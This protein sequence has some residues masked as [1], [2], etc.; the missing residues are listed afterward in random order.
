MP[1]IVISEASAR[2]HALFGELQAPL[3]SFLEKRAEAIAE[4][5]IVNKI[6]REVKSTHRKEGYSGMTTMGDFMP[7]PENGAY[8]QTDF[9]VAYDKDIV[10]ITWKNRFSVSKEMMDDTDFKE[11]FKRAAGMMTDFE[12]TREKFFFRILAEALQ[13]KKSFTANNIEVDVTSY[14]KLPMFSKSH[15]GKISGKTIGNA[16]SDEFSAKALSRASTVMQNYTDENGNP[17]NI[18]PDTILIGNDADLK[19]EVF[20]VIGSEKVPGCANN[21]Y[22]YLFQN[23]NV[24]VSPYLNLFLPEG[25]KPW[26]LLDSRMIQEQDVFIRQEREKLNITSRIDDNDANTFSGRYR[27]GGGFVDFRG[28]AAGG[29]NFGEALG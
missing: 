9:E 14:D 24:L 4:G 26:V 25:A 15:K 7:T 13:G 5:S 17:L 27:Q 22:N 6:T 8:P 28:M 10:N 23:W 19:E 11:I 1:G 29:L 18:Q 2:N 12:R 3:A 16:F 20:A 21:D